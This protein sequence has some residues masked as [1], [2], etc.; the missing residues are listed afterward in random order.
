[1]AYHTP[2]GVV[3]TGGYPGAWAWPEDRLR[4]AQEFLVDAA[5]LV[6]FRRCLS[7]AL[8]SSGLPSGLSWPM[9]GSD[10]MR[11]VILAMMAT[12]APAIGHAQTNSSKS[13]PADVGPGRV[14]WFDI[15]T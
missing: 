3:G 14:A 13:W 12:L 5:A 15:T 11:S 7:W 6:Q 2:A 8:A 10:G 4:R 9:K 1:M